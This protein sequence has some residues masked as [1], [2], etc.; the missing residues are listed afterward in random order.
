M[1]KTILLFLGILGYT[2]I[3]LSQDIWVQK[4][5][6][7][8]AARTGTVSFS[9][10]TKGYIGT[11]WEFDGM[12][13]AEL[14][15]F[16]EFDPVSNVW[17]QKADFGGAQRANAV[18]FSI[19][20]KGYIGTGV[21]NDVKLKDFWEYD[22]STNIWTQKADL[23]GSPR[24]SAVGFSIGNK[25]Y[26]GT[27][28]NPDSTVL[29]Y[30][31][32][33]EYN[34]STDTWTQM[35]D[36]GGTARTW[37][38]GFSIGTKGYIGTGDY[39]EKDFWEYDP[40]LDTW[41]QKA[42]FGGTGRNDAVGFSIG[43]KGYIGTGN[44]LCNDFWEYDLASDTWTQ[45]ANVGGGN[46]QEATGF[47][48]GQKG[49]I[50][51]GGGDSGYKKDL[52]EYTPS[53]NTVPDIADQLEINLS[54]NPAHDNLIVEAP[55]NATIELINQQGQILERINL[56]KTKTEINISNFAKG[57]YIVKL[58]GADGIAVKK[59]IKE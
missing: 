22:P 16:W 57:L 29:F 39:P 24:L 26:I 43:Q 48:I 33:W 25:G 35:A 2:T 56:S 32:F 30:K 31:D 3:V 46:R 20:N 34:P 17:I 8:G 58:I 42:D 6:L 51:M 4:A 44:P 18:G 28:F 55:I 11:G 21:S 10:G 19:G 59:F 37:A 40:A 47:S 50:G 13:M 41:T 5:N 49:Y 9:I 54:P 7:T 38:V 15:D 14:G 12:N 36:F 27:G 52:W 23:P 1:K 45:K 53:F